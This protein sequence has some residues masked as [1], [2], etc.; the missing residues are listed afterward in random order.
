MDSEAL[1]VYIRQHSHLFWD[2]RE[3]AKENLSLSAVVETILKY[4]HISDIRE[5]FEIASMKR[6]SEIFNR[7][8]GG[9][10]VNYHPRTVHFFRQYFERHAS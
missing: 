1:K 9:R 4:G 7:Q 3:G 10:R 6:I 5:L 8:I 2:I